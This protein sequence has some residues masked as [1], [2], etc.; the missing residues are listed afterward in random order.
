MNQLAKH[1]SLVRLLEQTVR[2]AANP[3][4]RATVSRENEAQEL[5]N[6]IDGSDRDSLKQLHSALSS[7]NDKEVKVLETRLAT[8][9]PS[10]AQRLSN[11]AKR[12]RKK[13]TAL[14]QRQAA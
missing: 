13:P 5:L 7:L 2:E 9:D 14:D 6:G 11:S 1:S 12:A 10:D 8:T 3:E 4:W